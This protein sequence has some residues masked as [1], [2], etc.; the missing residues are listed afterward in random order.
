M[1]DRYAR[2]NVPLT[3]TAADSKKAFNLFGTFA[4]S[5][6][7]IHSP[8]EMMRELVDNNRYDKKLRPKT[9]GLRGSNNNRILLGD[10]A[11]ERSENLTNKF[12]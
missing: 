6:M 3:V 12:A 5:P 4:K 9:A 1:T 8:A 10:K 2:D 11:V 7:S